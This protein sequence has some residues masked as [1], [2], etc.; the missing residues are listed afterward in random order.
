[1]TM[2]YVSFTGY[3]RYAGGFSASLSSAIASLVGA[4]RVLQVSAHAAIMQDR[5]LALQR[6]QN[7]AHDLNRQYQI[8]PPLALS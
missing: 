2:T 8:P 5:N 7:L 6:N 1:M 4:P 3:L